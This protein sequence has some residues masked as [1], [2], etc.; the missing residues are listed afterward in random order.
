MHESRHAK[1]S[2]VCAFAAGILLI[3]CRPCVPGS[4]PDAS[5]FGV[6]YTGTGEFFHDGD[7]AHRS[8]GINTRSREPPPYRSVLLRTQG[9]T[10]RRPG[11]GIYV[12]HAPQP[13]RP[14]AQSFMATYSRPL[15]GGGGESYVA[16]SGE[17]HITRSSPRCMTGTFRFTAVRYAARIPGQGRPL[18]SGD[19][20]QVDPGAP[21]IQVSGVFA[22]RPAPEIE[23]VE[24]AVDGARR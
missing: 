18:G 19:P 20:T 4:A 1:C 2:A 12:L 17:L 6:R 7:L 24:E 21:T 23:E 16:R 8:F 10:E 3:G 9:H 5:A 11:P 14:L 15:P 22:A 13:T